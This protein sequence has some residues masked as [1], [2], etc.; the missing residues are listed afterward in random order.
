MRSLTSL[1]AIYLLA[2]TSP[3]GAAQ[4]PLPNVSLV[5]QE[6][7]PFQL[8]D[9]KGKHLIVSFIFSRCPMPKMCPL[10]MRLVNRSLKEWK[11]AL[12]GTPVHALAVTLDPK[13]DT[14]KALKNYGK[15]HGVDF[16]LV[17]L[18]TGNEKTL[19]EFASEF[20]VIGVPEKGSIGH[21]LKTVLVGPDLIPIKH[22]KDNEWKPE[23]IVETVKASAPGR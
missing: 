15:Q 5:N 1:L 19:E 9:L 7:K 23:Q 10:T 20:N 6:G 22:F 16:S 8:Y 14:P 18:A 21:N 4:G 3:A 17:T 11:K 12:P 2:L 13:N